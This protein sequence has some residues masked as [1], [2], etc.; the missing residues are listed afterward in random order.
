MVTGIMWVPGKENPMQEGTGRVPGKENPRREQDVNLAKRIPGRQDGYLA[1]RIQVGNRTGP[2]Q[3][4][5]KEGTGCEPGKDNSRRE[6]DGFL[7]RYAH[8]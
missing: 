6:Q 2:W 5:S 8:T 7:C 1:K 4:E 3:R